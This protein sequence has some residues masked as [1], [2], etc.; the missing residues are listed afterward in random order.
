L[1]AL[2]P[3]HGGVTVNVLTL[4][5][6]SLARRDGRAGRCGCAAFNNLGSRIRRFPLE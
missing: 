5:A 2:A 1:C 6:L 3:A 4:P